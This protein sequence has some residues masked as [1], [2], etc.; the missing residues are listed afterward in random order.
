[1]RATFLKDGVPLS[2]ALFQMLHLLTHLAPIRCV[3]VILLET[4]VFLK[5]EI[6]MSSGSLLHLPVHHILLNHNFICFYD[7]ECFC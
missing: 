1:M 6:E 4:V 7:K 5:F 3:D 2:E